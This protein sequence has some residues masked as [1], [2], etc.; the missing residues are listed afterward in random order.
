M[1]FVAGSTQARLCGRMGGLTTAA[2]GTGNTTAGLDAFLATFEKLRNPTAGRRA[3]MLAI[4]M[5]SVRVRRGERTAPASAPTPFRP[6]A[7]R[8]RFD[9]ALGARGAGPGTA[10]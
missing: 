5:E 8:R 2:R 9:P 4:G 7:A 1:T 3:Y 6:R 10:A